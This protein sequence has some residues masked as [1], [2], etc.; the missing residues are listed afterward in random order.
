MPQIF[1][2]GAP[3]IPYIYRILGAFIWKIKGIYG[4]FRAFG[5]FLI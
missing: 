5:A 1:Y 3:N 2:I 4:I